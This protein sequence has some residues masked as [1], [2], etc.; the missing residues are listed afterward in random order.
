[1]IRPARAEDADRI[2]AIFAA[3]IASR[4]TYVFAPGT[5]PEEA[6][7]YWFGP[8]ISTWVAEVQGEVIGMYKLIANQRDL[9]AHVAN[10]SFMVHPSAAGRGAGRAMALHCLR[11]A[12][13]QG[14]AAMQFNFVVSSNVN[15][16]HLW[17]SL[18]FRIVGTLPQVFRHPARGLI[19]AYVMHRFLDDIT[20][21]FGDPPPD[22]RPVHRPS[23][24][25]VIHNPA[26][27]RLA[28][29]QAAEGV[30]LPGGGIDS[31]ETAQAAVLREVRE[32]C[33]LAADITDELGEVRQFVWSERRQ[34]W[35]EKPSRFYAAVATV[36]PGAA[37]EHRTEWLLPEPAAQAVTCES[38]AWAIKRW[39]RTNT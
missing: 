8:G 37:A 11:E 24:Y 7:A 28:V 23:A 1:M 30:L 13:L 16:V 12:R 29:V 3:V 20:L 33:G 35:L 17:Q 18:G 4:D 25:A 5:S 38:H 27:G 31:C 15:A 26:E 34:Q 32:E 39:A 10:A 14:F 22:A 9:G 21:S 6:R 2:C 36:L 19:D